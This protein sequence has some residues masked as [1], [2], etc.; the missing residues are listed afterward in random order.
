[1]GLNEIFNNLKG[2][3]AWAYKAYPLQE[4]E[5]EIVI[6][7]LDKEKPK[8][9]IDEHAGSFTVSGTCP[10]CKN[11]FFSAKDGEDVTS[12]CRYCGQKLNWSGKDG[13]NE[14]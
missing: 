5:A 13:N 2:W 12:Y 10:V 8:K 14:K 6:R 9:L 4:Y 11:T 3:S 1:M 7:A